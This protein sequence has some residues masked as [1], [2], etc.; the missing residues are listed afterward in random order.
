MHKYVFFSMG[1]LTFVLAEILVRY[2]GKA[3]GYSLIY[4]LIP[5]FSIPI[6]YLILFKQ[7]YNENLKK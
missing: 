7:F 2:S 3:Y 5:I 1:F 4:Y 6:F